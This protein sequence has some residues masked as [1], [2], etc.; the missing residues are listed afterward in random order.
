MTNNHSRIS[1]DYRKIRHFE[2]DNG[3][4]AHD[5]A[6]SDPRAGNQDGT[7]PHPYVVTEHHTGK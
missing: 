2:I 3:T 4:R 1:R 5:R 6:I 7:G